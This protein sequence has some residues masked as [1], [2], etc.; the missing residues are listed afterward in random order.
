MLLL[1]SRMGARMRFMRVLR[2][3]F[4]FSFSPIGGLFNS[5]APF[6]PII[7]FLF[8]VFLFF[9]FSLSLQGKNPTNPS[10][11]PAI[12][13]PAQ[14]TPLPT[15]PEPPKSSSPSGSTSTTTPASQSPSRSA[16]GPAAQLPRTGHPS[17]WPR[18]LSEWRLGLRVRGLGGGLGKL[19]RR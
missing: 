17:V 3:S 19:V 7:V 14:L 4:L 13:L 15:A 12:Y 2:K 18:V 16:P 10:S 5:Q 11:T 8:S 1:L 6:L 9:F